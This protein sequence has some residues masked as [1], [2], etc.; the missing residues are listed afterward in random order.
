MLIYVLP[1]I[2]IIMN[3]RHGIHSAIAL[4]M[5]TTSSGFL[6]QIIRIPNTLHVFSTSVNDVDVHDLQADLIRENLN[7]C[8]GILHSSGVRELNDLMYLT[9]QQICEMRLNQFDRQS[10]IRIKKSLISN[11]DGK[12]DNF[13]KRDL[14]TQRF[15][16]FDRKVLSRFDI[17]EKQ[18]FEM[19][20]ISSDNDVYKGTL[21]SVAQCQQLN[22]MSEYYAYSR[23]KIAN[24]GWSNHLYTLTS[25]HMACEVRQSI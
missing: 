1:M 15:G 21:F 7:Q 10:I 19:Q 23:N 22:R 4:I 24:G 16:A 2:F 11:S 12:Y 3:W 9:D 20:T 13:Q 14:S 6:S 18:D 8:H 17:E 5:V 25:Q